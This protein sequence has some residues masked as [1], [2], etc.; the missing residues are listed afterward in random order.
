MIFGDLKQLTYY[1]DREKAKKVGSKV[2]KYQLFSLHT[3]STLSK[4]PDRKNCRGYLPIKPRT[5][6]NI[7]VLLLAIFF[8]NESKNRVSFK[9]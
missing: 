1:T 7:I 4:H 8:C 3:K 6:K 5:Y 9:R 2:K